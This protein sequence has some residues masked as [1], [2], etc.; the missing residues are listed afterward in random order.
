MA[1]ELYQNDRF[2]ISQLYLHYS[3]TSPSRGWS[4]PTP[5][6]CAPSRPAPTL[7]SP[8]SKVPSRTLLVRHLALTYLN[9]N[10]ST[11]ID[12]GDDGDSLKLSLHKHSR[13]IMVKFE[14]KNPD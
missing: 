5:V 12:S 8:E 1:N 7:G 6:A 13:L 2:N 9:P 4:S 3:A 11:E 14:S 10:D